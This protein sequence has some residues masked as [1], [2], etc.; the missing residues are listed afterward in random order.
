M[1]CREQAVQLHRVGGQIAARGAR[2]AFVGNGNRHFARA[3]RDEFGITEPL[4]VDTKRDAYRALELRRGLLHLADAKTPAR[5]LRALKGGFRQG[6]TRGD[7]MQLGGVVVVS[8]GGTVAYRHA[9]DVPG[10]HPPEKDV[11][12]ALDRIR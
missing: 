2:L 1:F 9:S 7:T 6:L 3:F 8:P 4:Y 11:L 12:K 10:D 5:M